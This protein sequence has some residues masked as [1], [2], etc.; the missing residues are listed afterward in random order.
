MSFQRIDG[1]LSILPGTV[2]LANGTYLWK[3][4]ES[5]EAGSVQQPQPSVLEILPWFVGLVYIF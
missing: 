2:H 1:S 4:S 5:S 3:P